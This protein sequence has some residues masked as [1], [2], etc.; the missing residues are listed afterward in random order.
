MTPQNEPSDTAEGAIQEIP[1]FEST[2]DIESERLSEP[3]DA[4]LPPRLPFT[5]VGVGASAGGLEAYTDFLQACRTDSGIAFVLIQHLSPRHESVMAELLAKHTTMPVLQVTDSLKV[6]PNHVYVIRPGY[7]MTIRDGHLHLGPSAAERMQRRPIDDFFRSLAEEQRDRAICVILSGTGSNGTAGAQSIKAVGGLCI[8]QDPD[9]AKFPAMPRSLIDTGLA[10]AI[11]QPAEMF[12]VI[13]RFA[14]RTERNGKES[15]ADTIFRRERQAVN[16]VIAILRTRLRHD[17]SG[18]KKPT[19]V[20]RIQRR[21]T[22]LQVE[23]MPDYVRHLRQN[24][25]EVT[26]LNDDLM[27]HVTGFFRDPEVWEKLSERVIVPL[28]A[29]K[30]DGAAIRCWVTA[31]SSGE[32]AY[33]LGILLLEAAEAANKRFDIKIFA[34]DTAE[35]SLRDA[36]AGTFAGGIES[37][38]QPKRLDRFFEKDEVFYRVRKELREL[39]VFAP[40]NVLQ[41]PPFSRLDIC[42]CRNLLIYIE[43]EVQRRVLSMIHFGL[44]EGGTLLLGTSETTTGA[45]DLFEPIDKKYRLFRR[46]GPTRHGALDFPLPHVRLRTGNGNGD[47]ENDADGSHGDMR[48]LPRAAVQSLAAKAL[49]DRFTPAAM[50]VDRAGEI[51]YFHGSTE[52]FLIQP[53]GEPTRDMLSLAREEVRGSLRT[54][55][56]RSLAQGMS[57]H[58]RDGTIGEGASRTRIEVNV[59]PLDGRPTANYFLVTFSEHPEPPP[60]NLNIDGES[61]TQLADEL[62]RVRDEL[63]STIEELQTSNEEMKASHEEVTS[64]NEELQSTNEELETSKEELQSLNEE[65]TTVNAQLQAKMEELERTT[66]DLGSLLSS[67]DIA[68]IFLDTQFRI[69]R[70]TPAM[71][72][73]MDLIPGDMGRPLN[74]MA[75]KFD[76][77]ELLNDARAVLE[78]LAP[79]EREIVS[80]EGRWYVRRALPYRTMDSRIEGVVITFVDIN[81]RRL[82]E[83]ARQAE[84]E[85]VR[86]LLLIMRAGVYQTNMDG[87]IAYYNP[88]AAELWGHEPNLN[89]AQWAL[90]GGWH[91]TRPDGSRVEPA[92]SP[93]ADV[94]RNGVPVIDLEVVLERKDHSKIDVLSNI[95]PLRDPNGTLVGA[96]NVFQDISELKRTELALRHAKDAA[97]SASRVKDEFLATLS[98]ELRTPLSAILIWAQLLGDK[99][100]APAH[101]AEGLEVIRQSGEA[102]KRLIEDL[103][104]SAR[105]TSGKLR[106]DMAPMELRPVIEETIEAVLP[107][108]SA[109]QIVI[110]TDFGDEI[111][112]VMADASRMR[113]IAWNL[114]TNA[115]KFSG[116]RQRIHVALHQQHEQIIFRIVDSGRGIASD[117]LPHVFERF[118]QAESVTVRTAGGLGLGLAIVKQL[119]EMHNGTIQ[120]ESEGLGKGSAFTI[121]LPRLSSE[122]A[123]VL[124]ETAGRNRPR[125]STHG[126]RV[127]TVPPLRTDLAS[128]RILLVEDQPETRQA[129]RKLLEN[130]GAIV[131]EYGNATTAI[132]GFE[133]AMARIIV[134]DIGLPDIDG[135]AMLGRIRAAEA[136]TGRQPTPA[137]AL[138]AFAH[139]HEAHRFLAAGFQQVMAKPFEPAAFLDAVA[140]LSGVTL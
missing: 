120:V 56:Q 26:A 84:E 89:D 104:D 62:R 98:H 23:T 36:R 27:I 95:T 47:G 19:I 25:G 15:D 83:A 96:V 99:S 114:L 33:T 51:V 31:C 107:T 68:V 21:M 134:A 76:D 16:E 128:A 39:V 1:A 74:D 77:P 136:A 46:I 115:V 20:R 94:L 119:V 54:A 71:K 14:A 6:E 37:E 124:G 103:L 58:V 9:S 78:R 125:E 92:N 80:S 90:T 7:T 41:D 49:L 12:T 48:M 127:A 60:P 108:A 35:R 129:V 70:Y 17:F 132:A 123:I 3:V 34:T 87:T 109:K 110:D 38:I 117:F 73:L 101:L 55:F 42:T 65:L 24:P 40:Q 44:R 53:R 8:A 126:I 75:R 140:A 5:V 61:N 116:N 50:V 18:Y 43:P 2:P 10:D 57:V 106:L 52:R 105:I 88:R 97:E 139:D 32:E 133:T 111:G 135:C 93:M 45:E 67:T 138:T 72:D 113:Q 30:D 59:S 102:Q 79:I 100:P 13:S 85:R 4:E 82:A 69:R 112:L 122:P 81:A 66:N 22:L 131:L 86:D 11:L 29:E 121:R 64:V 137:L 130:A 63:Q 91:V 28:V 118:R